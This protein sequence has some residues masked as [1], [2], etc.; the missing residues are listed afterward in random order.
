MILLALLATVSGCTATDGDTIRCG[1][2]RIR[3]IGIDAPELR[4]HCRR[5]RQCAPGDLY[6]S[7]RSLAAAMRP[8]M[9]IERVTRDRYGRTIADVGGLSCR[10]LRAGQAVYRRDWDNGGRVRAQCPVLAAGKKGWG[11]GPR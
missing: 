11:N 1:A 2:E 8:T 7:K 9:P 6:A 4:G 5:G 10:Q 3:L